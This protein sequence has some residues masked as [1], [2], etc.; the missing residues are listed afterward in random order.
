MDNLEIMGDNIRKKLI[1]KL[2]E[3]VILVVIGMMTCGVT[4]AECRSS[5]GGAGDSAGGSAGGGGADD[6]GFR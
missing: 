3:V 4:F 6:P 1:F 5:S 2:C